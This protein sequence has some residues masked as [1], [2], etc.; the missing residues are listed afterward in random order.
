MN[1][2][3]FLY[4][5]ISGIIIVVFA[6][7]IYIGVNWLQDYLRMNGIML[8]QSEY[9]SFEEKLE[10]IQQILDSKYY[11]PFNETDL[12]EGIYDGYVSAIGDPY[13]DYYDPEEF[14]VL[15]EDIHGSYEGIGVVISFGE[16]GEDVEV[17][18]P[19]D[20]SP[21]AEAGLLPKDKIVAVDGVETTG[22]S[23]EEV[24]TL[25][26]GE[27]GTE[28]VLTIYRPQTRETI[29]VP[30][31]RDTIDIQTVYSEMLENHIGYIEISGFQS[32]THEQ[33]LTALKELDSQEMNGLIIDLRNNPGGL[34]NIVSAIADEL[35]PEGLIVY[36]EYSDGT[37]DEI[38]SDDTHKFEKPLVVLVNENSASASEILAGAIKDHK[39]GKII[40]TTTFGKGLVQQ[41]Y[42]LDDG[43]AIK[44]TVAKY[45]T[46]SGNY[47][48]DVGI[49]PDIQIELPEEYQNQFYI[50]REHD[51]QLEKAIEVLQ[52]EISE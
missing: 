2:K 21:G 46:P 37:R 17:V 23:L 9:S 15:M 5:L 6:G 49:I 22:M 48:H 32:V 31:I 12:V 3:S 43:S 8:G 33:F 44:V 19:F 52:Q 40:G 34:V 25:I 4:G 13:T 38:F 11:E 36:T 26:K 20:G 50:D 7:S 41:T 29:E 51:T 14:A 16:N 1:K 35:L 28:V 27:K 10:D 47:I 45:F 39:V 42:P 30:I 18:S 24:V